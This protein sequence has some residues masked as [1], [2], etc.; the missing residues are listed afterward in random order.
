MHSLVPSEQLDPENAI[1]I[2]DGVWWV[3]HYLEGDP[4]QC[5]VYLIEHGDQSIL[6]DPGSKLTFNHTLRKIEQVTSFSNIRY[7]VCQHQDPDITGAMQIID[8]MIS[9]DDAVLVT[10][11]RAMVL[12]RHYD[13]KI[14]FWLVNENDWKLD[15]GGRKLSFTFTPYAHF[16]GA[17]CSFDEQTR[18]LFSSDLFG[19]FTEGFSL[20]AKDESYF[21]SL[22]PFHEH[23]MPSRDILAFAINELQQ[24][25]IKIIAPQ[26]GSIIPDHLVNFMMENLKSLDCGL[27]LLASETSD[28]FSISK[29]NKILQ[30][31]TQTMVLYRDFKDIVDA[32]VKIIQQI[33]PAESLEFY[34]QTEIHE[35]DVLH[36]APET[37]YRGIFTP[38]PKFLDDLI[39]VDKSK[40]D[41]E[42]AKHYVKITG[43]EDKLPRLV[44]PLFNQEQQ[45]AKNIV[46][47]KLERDITMTRDIEQMIEQTTIPLQVAV[48]R[49]SIYRFLEMERQKHYERSIRD[50]LTGLFT[51]YYMN[52]T[53]QRQFEIHD[54]EGEPE[55]ALAMFDIDHFKKVNDTFGHNVGDLVLTSIAAIIRNSSRGGDI[56]VRLGGEEFALFIIGKSATDIAAIAERTRVI[57]ERT[58]FAKLGDQKSVTISGGIGTRVKKETLESF[59]KRVDQALYEAKNSG[60][61]RICEAVKP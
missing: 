56:P 25:D 33:L 36:L 47:I 48:E 11:W 49:E 24:H 10:H 6:F 16:P 38:A 44:I 14:P 3:G 28:I 51:R 35:E 27:F 40:Y 5:H 60:R 13:L 26:H 29:M 17:F 30:E 54:R 7:F 43:A 9:R 42:Q 34:A 12:L 52:E 55:I 59:F 15:I 53:L 32:L 31:I 58:V 37:R 18:T 19:G 20:V 2:A 50:S 46:I 21:E 1:E 61:N 8:K 57:V 39:G 45:T 4:F 41:K 22:R 23:Y